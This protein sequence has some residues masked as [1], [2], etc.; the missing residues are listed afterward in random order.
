M[1]N[2]VRITDTKPPIF[3]TA[4]TQLCCS[5]SR[6][7]VPGTSVELASSCGRTGASQPM[8]VPQLKFPRVMVTV[9]QYIFQ[10]FLPQDLA[11]A[12]WPGSLLAAVLA[13][14]EAWD[15]LSVSGILSSVKKTIR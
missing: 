4:A 9:A 11:L 15:M 13:K 7:G 8:A 2:P 12:G 3:I 10:R 1:S 5:R 6:P 14:L